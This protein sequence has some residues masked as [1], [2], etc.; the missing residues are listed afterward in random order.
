MK[1][2]NNILGY[3]ER[4]TVLKKQD[5]AQIQKYFVQVFG[6]EQG[7]MVL[8]YLTLLVQEKALPPD[9]TPAQL[10]YA[11]GQRALVRQIQKLAKAEFTQNF[12]PK[13]E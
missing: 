11:E 2:L 12:Q 5:S 3:F 10:H 1:I 4:R 9:A 7:Q 13:G 6:S 8:A